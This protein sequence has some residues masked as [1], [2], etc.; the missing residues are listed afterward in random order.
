MAV[1]TRERR[2][3]R[4]FITKNSEYHFRDQQC[5]AVK[6]LRQGTWLLL[7]DALSK[8]FSGTI[9]FGAD[10]TAYPTLATPDVGDALF[11]GDDSGP[12]LITSVIDCVE[13]PSKE[14]VQSYPF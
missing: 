4:K 6:C 13:R 1:A 3:R 5:V 11:F 7:H 14:E 2:N 10:G 9:R 8:P 12:E